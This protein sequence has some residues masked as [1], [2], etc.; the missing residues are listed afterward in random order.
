MANRIAKKDIISVIEEPNG[1]LAQQL[2]LLK[3]IEIGEAKSDADKE[4]FTL[5]ASAIKKTEKML[6]AQTDKIRGKFKTKIAA[7]KEK[8]DTLKNEQSTLLGPLSDI[9]LE[10]RRIDDEAR[11]AIGRYATTQMAA[12]VAEHKDLEPHEKAMLPAPE[13]KT[14]RINGVSMSFRDHT[15]VTVKN[16]GAV[17]KNFLLKAPSQ[18]MVLNWFVGK[19]GVP[20]NEINIQANGLVVIKV[21]AEDIPDEL[22][23]IVGVNENAIVAAGGC[24]G[25]EMSTE[26][27]PVVKG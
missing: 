8:L 9:A 23:D 22:K 19:T 16:L 17:P 13:N 20:V 11:M 21:K 24:A 12:L 25:V 15:V 18:Q 27:R 5:V 14:T 2:G 3:N 6:K 1:D 7:A 10:L 26:K 4:L